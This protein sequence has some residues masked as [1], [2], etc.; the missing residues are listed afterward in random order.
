M[1]M[2]LHFLLMM[3]TNVDG[4][5]LTFRLSATF[6]NFHL[7]QKPISFLK[8]NVLHPP[9]PLPPPTRFPRKVHSLNPIQDG[10][11]KDPLLVFPL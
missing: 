8:K 4:S 1:R 7:L 9:S 10:G 6:Q 2:Q 5:T 11:Q 3:E